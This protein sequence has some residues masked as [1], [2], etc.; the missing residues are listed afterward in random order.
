M[1]TLAKYLSCLC[2]FTLGAAGSAAADE[3][4]CLV[5]DDAGNAYFEGVT[6]SA[7][8]AGTA[9]LLADK[10]CG[11]KAPTVPEGCTLYTTKSN[12]E[13]GSN[14]T[15]CFGS[16]DFSWLCEDDANDGSSSGVSCATIE[17]PKKVEA[18][19]AQVN[20]R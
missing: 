7:G 13:D 10:R 15:S 11:C 17:T 20:L 6:Y 5:Y 4:A 9:A 14:G 12:C 19:A 3:A 18:G 8:E 1:K 16:C 2:I